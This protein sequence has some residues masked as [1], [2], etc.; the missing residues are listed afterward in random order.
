MRL[1][2]RQGVVF[3]ALVLVIG[4]V[5]VAVATALAV[6]TFSNVNSNQSTRFSAEA[7]AVAKAGALDGLMRVVYDKNFQSQGYNLP[8]GARTA[9]I[10][11]AKDISATGET[12]VCSTATVLQRTVTLHSVLS[13]DV[14]TGLVN[15]VSTAEAT[16]TAACTG[17]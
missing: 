3:L 12:E 17:A 14:G 9:R 7:L 1:T 11:V 15:L 10:I 5:L 13:V 16:S 2:Q 8:V 4:G 6:L